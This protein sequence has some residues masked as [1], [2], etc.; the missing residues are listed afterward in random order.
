MP[1]ASLCFI[2][3]GPH[4]A[5][6]TPAS[7][8]KTQTSKCQQTCKKDSVSIYP[9]VY[10]NPNSNESFY[11]VLYLAKEQYFNLNVTDIFPQAAV[12]SLYKCHGKSVFPGSCCHWRKQAG[13]KSKDT[14]LKN[15]LRDAIA[16]SNLKLSITHSLT[17]PLT[18]SLTYP[19]TDIGRC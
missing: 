19:L 6:N 11:V 7:K 4:V 10:T 14:I 16:I 9:F 12:H 15:K 13:R 5:T 18:H 2:P 8:T 17:Y 3:T 1:K